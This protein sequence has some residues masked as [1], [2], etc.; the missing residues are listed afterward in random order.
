M[1][2]MGGYGWS[3]DFGW[4]LNRANS[5]WLHVSGCREKDRQ[6]CCQCICNLVFSPVKILLCIIQCN[7]LC[8]FSC[9]MGFWHFP[10]YCCCVALCFPTPL[11]LPSSTFWLRC[12]CC[13]RHAYDCFLFVRMCQWIVYHRHPRADLLIRRDAS[14][15]F[16]KASGINAVF[17]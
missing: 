2:L 12:Y 1:M 10:R 16:H 17:V 5:H 9:A 14:P 13:F 3:L 11:Q 7:F 8:L 4:N 6:S 15:H